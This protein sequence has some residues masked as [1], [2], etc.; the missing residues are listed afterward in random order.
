ML[1]IKTDIDE[2]ASQPCENNGTCSD[3]VNMFKCRCPQNFTG[4][5]CESGEQ[6]KNRIHSVH[7][8]QEVISNASLFYNNEKRQ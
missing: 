1:N 5:M 8:E 4:M 6:D 3:D 7:R 2:C